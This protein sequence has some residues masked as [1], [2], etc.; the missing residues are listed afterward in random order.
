MTL[1]KCGLVAP[2]LTAPR[3]FP[4]LISYRNDRDPLALKEDLIPYTKP[5]GNWSQIPE[6]PGT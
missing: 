3:L 5:A 4:V 6:D 1:D 2:V